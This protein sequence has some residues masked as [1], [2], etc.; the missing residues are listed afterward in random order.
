MQQIHPHARERYRAV[1]LCRSL[2][3]Y[4]QQAA[5]TYDLGEG[6]PAAHLQWND[7]SSLGSMLMVSYSLL[8]FSLRD[9]FYVR[10]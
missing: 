8:L 3:L 1:C 5:H 10:V 6:S 4:P 7:V 2:T 9:Q